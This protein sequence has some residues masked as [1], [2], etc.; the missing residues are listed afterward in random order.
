MDKE[1]TTGP[2]TEPWGTPWV[3]EAAEEE[4]KIPRKRSVIQI[5]R[6]TLQTKG[7]DAITDPSQS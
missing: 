2:K 7:L 1:N 6:K 3:I 4:Q 5:W